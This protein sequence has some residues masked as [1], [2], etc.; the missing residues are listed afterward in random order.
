MS[1]DNQ[2]TQESGAPPSGQPGS[3][4][5]TRPPVPWLDFARVVLDFLSK[6]FYPAILATI[7]VALWPAFEA[8]DFKQLIGRLQSARAGDYEFTF[9]QA[10]DVGA[11]I[12][13]L[14]SKIVDLERKLSDAVAELQKLQAVSS[15]VPALSSKELQARQEEERAIKANSEYT[16][17]VFNRASSRMIGASITRRLLDRGYQ[18]SVTETDFS[19]LQKVTPRENLIFIVYTS[20]GA[21]ILPEI[22]QQLSQLA[23]EAEVKPNPRATNLKRGDIQVFVF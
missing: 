14:N 12:A 8:I 23:P 5:K 9:S 7:L 17:L 21:E 13:P 15:K 20:K 11:E 4:A 3:L 10:Q 1:M 16:V 6:C 22:Q 19:E 18:S 2:P